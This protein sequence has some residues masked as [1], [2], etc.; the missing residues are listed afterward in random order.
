MNEEE[1]SW[2]GKAME[3][4]GGG[5]VRSLYE[6]MCH[7]DSHNFQRLVDAFPEIIEQYSKM[8]KIMKDKKETK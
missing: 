1:K 7:A 2:M 5:F 4:Y 8:G 3:V 6:C